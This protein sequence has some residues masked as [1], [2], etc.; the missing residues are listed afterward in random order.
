M[1]NKI[2]GLF[3]E[4]GAQYDK[5]K[6]HTKRYFADLLKS[7]QDVPDSVIE[8][9]RHSHG[10]LELFNDL[11]KRLVQGLKKAPLLEKRVELLM[12][13]D[14]IGEIGALTW[15]LEIGDPHRFRS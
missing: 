14:G 6:L 11:Q 5:K 15:A 10:F 12:T 7:V 3:M 13:I 9:A 2:S 8:M 4:V 1:K